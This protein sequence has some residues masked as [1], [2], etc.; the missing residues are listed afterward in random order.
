PFR[1]YLSPLNIDPQAPCFA[2]SHPGRYS[3][4][5]SNI[6]GLY[7]TQGMPHANWP[8]MEGMLDEKAFLEHVDSI[9]KDKQAIL[10][11]A[12]E[13]FDSGCLFFYFEA[14]DIIQH[15]FFRQMLDGNSSYNDVVHSY[16]LK[17]DTMLGGL[18]DRLGSDTLVLVV[19]DHGFCSYDY[20]FDLNRW[21]IENG[22]LV[23]SDKVEKL[24]GFLEG[25]DW[26]KT[27]AYAL[28]YGNLYFNRL[29]RE[30]N[31]ILTQQDADK[32]G[33]EI[34]DKLISIKNPDNSGNVVYRVY[35]YGQ[36]RYPQRS[37]D[38]HIGLYPNY[39]FSWET[40]LGGASGKVIAAN[41]T[42]WSGTHF[43]DPDF[44]PGVIFSN[45]NLGIEDPKITDIAEYVLKQY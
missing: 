13:K 35:D 24:S 29:G 45:I 4:E 19:S 23:L 17:M 43:I 28:G 38:M 15:M 39:S 14:L 31:G 21:L 12:L 1:L 44:V 40:A 11:N 7:Y 8:Y 32:I 16:Y 33:R 41:T 20:V 3:E 36:S 18:M 22:Y 10:S 26:H 37:P 30:Q 34:K 2:I 27:K 42:Q 25:I 9:L 5:I 6:V